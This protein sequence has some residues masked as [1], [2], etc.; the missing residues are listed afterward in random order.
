[1]AT[2]VRD[3]RSIITPDAFK[4]SEELLGTP[5]GRPW[6]RF[7]ALVIDVVVIAALSVV[8]RNISLFIWGAVGLFLVSMAFRQ[9]AKG[10][11]QTTG[12]LFRGATGCLGVGIL[13]VSLLAGAGGVLL[14]NL[15][16][17]GGPAPPPEVLERLESGDLTGLSE[18]GALRGFAEW[19]GRAVLGQAADTAAAREAAVVLLMATA[20]AELTRDERRDV[21]EAATPG[22][23]VWREE[24][25]VVY[26]RALDEVAAQLAAREA[27]AGQEVASGQDAVTEEFVAE[28]LVDSL[29]TRVA[30]MDDAELAAS[31]LEVVRARQAEARSDAPEDTISGA[32]AAPAAGEAD[33]AEVPLLDPGEAVARLVEAERRR[34][35]QVEMVERFATD[36][37]A[38]L[39][40]EIRRARRAES[41]ATEEMA[42]VRRELEENQGGFLALLRD[43]WDQLGSAFGLWSIYF[44]VA[45]TLTGGRTVGKKLLG[46]RVLRLD[47]EPLT[48]WA[49]FERAGGYAAG[50]ATGTMGFVQV[51]WDANR[52]CVHDKIGGTVVVQDGAAPEP[53]A[54][55]QAWQGGEAGREAP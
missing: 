6:R 38:A 24:A 17:A 39:G 16:E 2:N 29:R 12:M 28:E 50:I 37:V 43:I 10:R 31:W 23:A 47:G 42:E 40:E 26:R 46:L 1:M 13:T 9:P 3:P 11:A 35:L 7:W 22:E 25:E 19:G 15:G 27:S 5:L 51:F 41:E 21:L 49:S 4:V 30:E 52:Q 55:E 34:L 32:G 14:S 33:A 45:L 53:G 20:P 36:T 44:T 54:W 18:L 48:W 8:T